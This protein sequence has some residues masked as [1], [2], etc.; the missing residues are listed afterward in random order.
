MWVGAPKRQAVRQCERALEA[1]E[2]LD[3]WRFHVHDVSEG[4]QSEEHKENQESQACTAV[5]G[6][7]WALPFSVLSRAVS[8]GQSWAYSSDH[9]FL[10]GTRDE[11]NKDS[12]A[13]PSS[14]CSKELRP[15]Q[16]GSVAELCEE[17]ILQV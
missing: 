8:Q 5:D 13:R 14:S 6:R 3:L 12:V 17:F 11:F 10:S 16:R 9:S 1:A 2:L 4:Q 7:A 15:Q